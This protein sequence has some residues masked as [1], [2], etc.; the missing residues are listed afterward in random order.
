LHLAVRLR[1]QASGAELTYT[2]HHLNT[3]MS[4]L[5]ARFYTDMLARQAPT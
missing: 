3:E 2:Y 4:V 1:Q 5:N